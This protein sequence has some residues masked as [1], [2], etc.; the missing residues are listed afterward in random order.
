MNAESSTSSSATNGGSAFTVVVAAVANLGIAVAKAVAGLIS[1]SSA[2]LSEAAHSVADTVTEV[3][4]LTALKR[5][6][7]PADEEHPLG[8]GPE[9]YIWALLASVA[10]F[11]GGAVFA[12]YDGIH[13]LVRGEELGDP[14]VSYLVLAVAFLL[15]SV[16]LRTGLRQI[17]AEAA[18]LG[19][20]TTH[21]LRHTSDTAVKAV[22]MEDSAALVGLL[23][24]AGGLLGGQLSGSGVWDGIASILI[25]V[26]LVY[27]AW[28]LGRSNAQLLIGRPLPEE[29]RAGVREEILSVPHIIEVMELT[30]LIQGPTE[31][32]V[33]A[34]VDFRD[35]STAEQIEWACEEAEEQLRER[36]PSIRRVYLDPTPGLGQRR[37]TDSPGAGSA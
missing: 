15:E 26:L 18:R 32:L 25:G 10:T 6:E 36:Y 35:A 4:L 30:T 16:S 19:A 9:R 37:R 5:S 3:L 33:A 23:L 13:T 20:P 28:V 27:V 31:V 29:M 8:H 14:L 34:K 24:A 11:V 7:K 22:V 12:F 1:G 2:M 21:Y 17:R